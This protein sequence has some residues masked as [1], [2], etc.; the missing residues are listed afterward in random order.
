MNPADYIIR[1]YPS[2]EVTCYPWV[3]H[4]RFEH[5]LPKRHHLDKIGHTRTGPY[6]YGK[7]T[8]LLDSIRE[9]GILNPFIIEY[10]DKHLPNAKGLQGFK[11]LAI[12][13]GN[14]RAEAMHQLGLTHAP[15]LF[16]VPR[17]IRGSLP[18]LPFR[19]LPI[20]RSLRH[21]IRMLWREIGPE[22]DLGPSDAYNDSELLMDLIR[23]SGN[24]RDG[25]PH[26]G[27]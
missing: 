23:E 22:G 2:V 13:T 26:R 25:E 17:D 14:N 6:D 24:V 3:Y 5:Y 10:Y 4:D 19:S 7:F 15:A 12:R 16:V 1:F 11:S 27:A 8:R 9:N 21:E 20:N 18:P